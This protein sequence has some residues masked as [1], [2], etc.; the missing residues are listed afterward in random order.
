M[1]SVLY[2]FEKKKEMLVFF[3]NSKPKMEFKATSFKN[4]GVINIFIFQLFVAIVD[5]FSRVITKHLLI[6]T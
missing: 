1:N 2:K 5:S 6:S 3:D 4:H